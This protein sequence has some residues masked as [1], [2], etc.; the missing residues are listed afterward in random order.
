MK[1]YAFISA[2]CILGSAMFLQSCDTDGDDNMDLLR[3]TAVVTVCPNDDGSFVMNLDNQTVLVPVN[4]SKSPYGDKEVRALVNY[5]EA[6]P[7]G[8]GCD[9]R[10]VT[11]NWI[12]SIRTKLPVATTGNDD[13]AF[14]NDPIEIVAD[15]VTVA[16]DGYITLRIRTLWDG[17]RRPHEL[18]LVTGVNPDDPFEMELRHNADGDTYGEMGDAL[19]A[20]NLND[21]PGFDNTVKIK[22]RWRS[23]SDEKSTELELLMR[24]RQDATPALDRSLSTLNARII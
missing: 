5:T 7:A 14:G 21:L 8:Y 2:A 16:E 17:S 13:E 4:M 20:F 9:M 11:V 22:L 10:D 24:T 23:F 6:G 18:N 3:P 1:K 15:W 19:I 12:D